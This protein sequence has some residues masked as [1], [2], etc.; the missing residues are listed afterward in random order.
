MRIL[1]FAFLFFLVL[2]R[3]P[4]PGY[5]TTYA[6]ERNYLVLDRKGTAWQAVWELEETG[7]TAPIAI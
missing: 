4:L 2:N 7:R 6:G 5:A 3:R 1:L